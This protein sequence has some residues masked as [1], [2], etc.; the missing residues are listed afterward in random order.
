MIKTILIS[1]Y[2]LPY[3]GI[4][5]WTNMYNYYIGEANHGIDII[6]CPEPKTKSNDISYHFIGHSLGQKIKN[7]ISKDRYAEIIGKLKTEIEP[8]NKY[9]IQMIDNHGLVIPLVNFLKEKGFRNQCYIQ[10]FYHGFSPFYGNFES[11]PF[12]ESIDE[13]VVLT[14]DSYLDYKNHY[15]ILPCRFSVQHNGI[16]K[17]RFMPLL[18]KEKDLLKKTLNVGD[19]TVF[20]WCSQDRPKKGLDFILDV[21]KQ[22]YKVHKNIHLWVVGASR[23]I[24]LPGVDFKG[25]IPHHEI[26]AFYQASDI[27]LYPSLCQEGFGLSLIEA[28]SCGN[29]CIASA[30]GG[31]PEVLDYGKYGVLV[32]HPNFIQEWL[33]A[34]NQ[35][36][37]SIDQYELKLPY[38]TYSIQTWCKNMNDKIEKAKTYLT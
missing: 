5:S 31:I 22:L 33:D 12:F 2:A 37:I 13:H 29:L 35:A 23:D 14:M 4:G 27:Y 21:W 17:S 20:L 10:F 30:N 18:K 15:S 28:L 1:Q 34:I 3:D 32:S 6:I 16:D 26:N 25:R 24:D 9:I 38:D 8:G 36:L 19:K 7:K 11:R